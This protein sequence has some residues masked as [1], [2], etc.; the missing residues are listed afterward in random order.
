[1]GY[2]Y[3][4]RFGYRLGLRVKATSKNVIPGKPGIQNFLKS[5]DS[6]FRRSDEI[7]IIRGSLKNYKTINVTFY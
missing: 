6:C 1:M 7:G 5:L 3:D 2:G 4:A